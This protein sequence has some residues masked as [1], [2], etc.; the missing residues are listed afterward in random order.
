ML[1]DI[2]LFPAII[3]IYLFLSFELSETL[4]YGILF[5]DIG[6]QFLFYSSHQLKPLD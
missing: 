3:F 4:S 1:I 5:D 2:V 6:R